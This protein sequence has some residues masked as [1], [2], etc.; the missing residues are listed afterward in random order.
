MFQDNLT[1]TAFN[2]YKKNG[3]FTRH[4][5]NH[6]STALNEVREFFSTHPK[7]RLDADLLEMIALTRV[8]LSACADILSSEGS[9]FFEEKEDRQLKREHE[10]VVASL[11]LFVKDIKN[12]DI[13]MFLHRQFIRVYGKQELHKII[14]ENPW[15]ALDTPE[16][17]QN[18]SVSWQNVF[19]FTVSS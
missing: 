6:V 5:L 15:I 9:T 19:S 13:H 3:A 1:N 12:T 18:V 17:E 7:S 10:S 4:Y 2:V 11:G 14:T 8:C 16:N